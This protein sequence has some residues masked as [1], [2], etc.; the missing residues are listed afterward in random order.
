MEDKGYTIE[1]TVT[2]NFTREVWVNNQEEADDLA[3]NLDEIEIDPDD[4]EWP[5]YDIYVE[6]VRRKSEL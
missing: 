4:L 2:F 6:D 3:E 5:P 1:G